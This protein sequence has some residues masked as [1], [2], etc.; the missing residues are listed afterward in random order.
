MD[1]VIQNE[2]DGSQLTLIP[3]G[4]FLAGDG[5][6]PLRLPAYYLG[7]HQVTNGQ[8]LQFVEATGHP[9]PDVAE[10]AWGGEPIWK[11]RAFPPE[12][13]DHPVVCVNWEDAKAYCDWAGLRL[14][15]EL[16]WEKGARGTDGREYPWG[17]QWDPGKCHQ[18]ALSTAPVEEYA[19]GRSVWGNLQMAGN[20]WE[21]CDDWYESAA[22]ERY[23]TGAPAAPQSGSTR[24]LRGGSWSSVTPAR[25]RCSNRYYC[26]PIQHYG[27]VGF[28]CARSI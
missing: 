3:A 14:P 22:Y 9:P 27:T 1:P 4:E 13:A 5:R 24:V 15:M 7:L 19:D 16:E 12:K 21:W 10:H 23:Q 6:F 2:K 18:A 8:Y 17:D 28:R 25:F 20:V 11:G 26:D